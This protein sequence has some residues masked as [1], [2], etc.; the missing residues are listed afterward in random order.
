MDFILPG[1]LGQEILNYLIQR[2]YVEVAVLVNGL[3]TI[4]PLPEPEP[5]NLTSDPSTV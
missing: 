1:D 5:V 4:K 2:P 3:Q